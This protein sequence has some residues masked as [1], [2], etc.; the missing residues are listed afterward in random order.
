MVPADT[1]PPSLSPI[2]GVDGDSRPSSAGGSGGAELFLRN[3][4]D[5]VGK[6]QPGEPPQSPSPAL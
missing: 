5:A 3:L 4:E 2:P 1:I 6:G